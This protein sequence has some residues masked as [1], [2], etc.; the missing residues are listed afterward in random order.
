MNDSETCLKM[1]PMLLDPNTS[2]ELT[3]LRINV[4]PIVCHDQNESRKLNY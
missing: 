1:E 3:V 4:S 2:I